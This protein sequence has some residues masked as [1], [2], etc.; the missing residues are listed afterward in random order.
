MI[1]S[2]EIEQFL[3]EFKYKSGFYGVSIDT[4]RAKNLQTMADLEL[5]GKHIIKILN[6]IKITD[7]SSGPTED[8]IGTGPPLWVFGCEVKGHEV[9]IKITMGNLSDN[10]VCVSFH[11]SE[12]PM[13][14][15][16][17]T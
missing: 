3:R 17:K 8:V 10:T 12:R 9:Y 5:S 13:N 14:Y 11:K 2:Q 16:Y 1:T 7:Y 6:G 4:E 15:P